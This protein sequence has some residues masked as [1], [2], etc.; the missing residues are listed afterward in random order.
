[1]HQISELKQIKLLDA[2]AL[3][4][5]VSVKRLLHHGASCCF[6]LD[7]ANVTPLHYAAQYNAVDIIRLL[8][9]YG[10]VLDARTIPDGQTPYD[11]AVLHDNHA[12]IDVL[13]MD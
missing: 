5:L 9:S 11:I 6:A 1:M 2:I 12:A 10:A 8:L 4:D 13:R 7:G 3:N